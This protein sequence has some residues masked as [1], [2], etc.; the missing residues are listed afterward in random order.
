MLLVMQAS[1][2]LKDLNYDKF[3]IE[4]V[5]C[6]LTTFKSDVLFELPFVVNLDYHLG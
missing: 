2:K 1:S 6:I 3:R 4:N 5:H